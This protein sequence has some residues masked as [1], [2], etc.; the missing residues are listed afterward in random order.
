MPSAGQDALGWCPRAV[1]QGRQRLGRAGL[2]APSGWRWGRETCPPSSPLSGPA[3]MSRLLVGFRPPPEAHAAASQRKSRGLVLMPLF[4][5]RFLGMGFRK[6]P[7]CLPL[8]QEQVSEA[9]P[10][11]RPGVCSRHPLV[12]AEF[13]SSWL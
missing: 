9:R 10:A 7:V 4:I 3:P 12:L 11:Q 8:G 6:V 5:S 13:I 2:G 1:T